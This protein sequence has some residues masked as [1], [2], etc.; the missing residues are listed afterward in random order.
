MFER[1]NQNILSEHFTKLI[2]HDADRAG[3]DSDDDFIT[4]KRADHEL[5][6]DE[7][8]EHDFIS[9]RKLRLA[10][11][12]KAIMKSGPKG[13]KLVF[14]DE[15][16]PHE[17]YEMKSAEEVFKGQD[18]A[19]EA[20]RQFAQSERSKLLEA[21]VL[22]RAEAKEKKQEKKRKRKER[23]REVSP[24]E[25]VGFP[26]SLT[27]CMLQENGESLGPTI[28]QVDDDGYVSP[29]FDLP[30]EQD[31]EEVREPPPKR[32]RLQQSN[33]RND[34]AKDEE[35]ALRLLQSRR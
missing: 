28:A 26:R 4:L 25:L 31:S 34:L 20:G 17:L 8:P 21:D 35:L 14:D 32:G 13:T 16:N 5:K 2:D 23:E 24:K 22:D 3:N 18:D 15:G 1:K 9:K 33:R 27:R 6:E 29:D 11:S 10:L 7:L 19:R 12:K 30:S